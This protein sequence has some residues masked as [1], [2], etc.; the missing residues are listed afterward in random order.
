M[1]YLLLLVLA[2]VWAQEPATF[3]SGVTLVHVNAEVL[4]GNRPVAD[5]DKNSFRITDAGKSQ[6]ILYFGHE[7]EPLDVALLLDE[8]PEMRPVIQ[9]VADAA[10]STLGELRKE[11]RLAVMTFGAIEGRCRADIIANFTTDHDAAE[12]IIATQVLKGESY[13]AN[14]NCG[15][16]AGLVG[17]SALFRREPEARRR[18]AIIILT[19][20]KGTSLKPAAVRN[21]LHELWQ[22]DAVV[23]GVIVR[24]GA[25]AFS[26]G[27][28]YRGVRYFAGQT[29]GDALDTKDPAPGVQQMLN[30]LRSRYS[31]YYA[32]PQGKA[33][34]E[35]KIEVQLASDAAK[36]YPRAVVR[37][38]TG[39]VMPGGSN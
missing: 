14:L 1:P 10:H 24:S 18:R 22:A 29:G 4:Q 37:A 6:T 15:V 8:R 35:R 32:L 19:D 36:R 33:G 3:R 5:L 2:L 20:D 25:V 17:A 23:L 13:P 26:I 11:D 7:E 31:L 12:R 28:P 38:R 39:Y 30:R 9:Q 16:H 27:P 34:E 21:T